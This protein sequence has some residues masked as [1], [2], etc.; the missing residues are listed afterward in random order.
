[1]TNNIKHI[2]Y[3]TIILLCLGCIFWCGLQTGRK[4]PKFGNSG[5]FP[6]KVD[7]LVI[8]DTTTIEKPVFVE[9]RVVE[10]V[11]YPVPVYVRDTLWRTD[12]LWLVREQVQWE[13]E[14][15]RVYASG[16]SPQVDSVTHFLTE[17][18]VTKEIPVPVKERSRWG[19]GVQVGYGLTLQNR[20]VMGAP[21]VGIGVTYNL[22]SW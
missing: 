3:G 4:H 13:D 22:F 5:G 12:T 20:Q 17:R 10:S 11:P 9:K 2:I 14:H 1:M 7:T 16:I 8:Y 15:C 21:Y 6:A 19:V 18:V